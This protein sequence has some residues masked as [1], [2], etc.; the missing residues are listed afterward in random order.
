MSFKTT[1]I[2]FGVVFALLVI[3]GLV[4]WLTSPT[5]QDEAYV[6]PALNDPST[7]VAAKE[8]D[9]V[10]IQKT[11]PRSER[12]AFEHDKEDERWS[13]TE[14]FALKEYR[15]DRG[16]V[17]RL[18]DEVMHA[19][20]ETHADVTSNLAEWG[21]DN[22]AVVVSLRKGDKEWKLNLGKQIKTTGGQT[23][24]VYVNTSERPKDVMAVRL[25]QLE[26][27][28]KD[29][30]DF[31]DK[32]LLADNLSEI[33]SVSLQDGKHDTVILK[34]A[35]GSQWKIAQPPYGS[36]DYEGEP[37]GTPPAGGSATPQPTTGVRSLLDLL[38][39]LKVDYQEGKVN[40]FVSEDARNLEQYGLEPGTK[41]GRL[42]IEVTRSLGGFGADK[43]KTVQETLLIGKK[44]D[45]GDKYYAMLEDEKYVVKVAANFAP[46]EKVL[47]D[48]GILRN[49]DLMTV[50]EFRIDALTA[51][52]DK[53][54][55]ELFKPQGAFQWQE[56]RDGK[57]QKADNTA[58]EGLLNALEAKRQISEFP[59]PK[60]DEKTLGLDQPQAVVSLWENG[61]QKDEE[62]KDEKKDDKKDT[63]KETKK[64]EKKD[65]T[66]KPK[67][68]SDKPTVK[69][70]FGKRGKD[71]AGKDVVYVRRETA[72][73]GTTLAAVP[74]TLLDQATQGPLAYAD[75]TLP[76]FTGE[77]TRVVIDHGG[78]T[79]ELAKEGASWKFKQPKE[80]AGRSA[81][82]IA[83][84][85]IVN[86]LRSLRAEKLVAEKATSEQ[87]QQYGLKPPKVQ[88]TVTVPDKD[89][90]PEDH[91][92]LFGDD[93]KDDRAA[94]LGVY[95]KEAKHDLVF[96][97]NRSVVDAFKGELRDPVL[98]HFDPAKVKALKLTGWYSLR[99]AADVIDLEQPSPGKWAV[100]KD[101]TLP[102]LNPDTTKVD[103]LVRTL[104]NLRIEQFL[105]PKAGPKPEKMDVKDD[106]LQIEITVEG[107]K[108]PLT[109]TVGG[110][111][112]DKHNDFAASNK[113]AGEP[114]L[115]WKEP[116]DKARKAP[117]YFSK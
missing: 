34:Q 36:A 54:T 103:E 49:R 112:P 93:A 88:V 67:L 18:V 92:Y 33:Q 5:P 2:L 94:L 21:L 48:P 55:A 72:D 51:K 61:I 78:Q 99:K 104:A 74:A 60:T 12:I 79:F 81:N 64:E 83:V 100:K 76:S 22:P 89:K 116:F 27:A 107:E 57:L 110:E 20:K 87:E 84:E 9:A 17:D 13:M 19:K 26:T 105:D 11:V 56:F 70:T 52:S 3:S 30:N 40:D 62:K 1:Y 65:A 53:G 58:V 106:A 114:F 7:P 97:V 43:N 14:P 109:L 108:E 73:E 98:F 86:D 115:V 69:L 45:K 4:L 101:S 16:A 50:P 71:K 37:V 46:L 35:T 63:A 15:V 95:A 24:V 96:T 28:F 68:K 85:G 38:T 8:I 102:M 25:N 59:D 31:R 29:A 80:W 10:T 42:R 32:N 75:K 90:K 82:Q 91:V 77:P 117:A 47:A 6:F 44:E 111:A 113:L 41:P 23:S 66:A 39:A